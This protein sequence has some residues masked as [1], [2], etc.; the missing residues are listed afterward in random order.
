M[1]LA[2]D[3]HSHS[4][5]SGG[6]GKISLKK[7]KE[8]MDKKGIDV[9]GT[10]DCLHPFWLNKLMSNLIEVKEGIF[11]LSPKDNKY[12]IL[13][14]EIV[15]TAPI[16]KNRRKSVHTVL[17]FPSFST[18][19]KVINLFRNYGVK[20]TIGRPFVTFQSTEEVSDFL[21]TLKA[22]DP[23]ITI[24]PAHIM[25]PDG[26]FGSNNPITYLEDFFGEYTENIKL[27]ETG[28]SADPEML[29]KI[30]QCRE[31]NYISNSD[32]HS[33]AIHRIGREFTLVEVD[34][35]SYPAIVKALEGNGIVSTY[36]FNPREGK[37][38]ASGHR[39]GKY[40]H[41]QHFYTEDSENLIC[42]HCKKPY[43]KGVKHRIEELSKAQK[44]N[45][46]IKKERKF[47]RI[48]PLVE[49]IAHGLNVKTLT[50]KRVISI[51]E[52][53]V[54]IAGSEVA[55]WLKS[56][57]FIEKE[58]SPFLD[59]KLLKTIISVHKGEFTFDPPG[60]DGEYGKLKI[61]V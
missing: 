1:L 51:Y 14:T 46:P 21:F 48:I 55:L 43:T 11:A 60:F 53:I 59:D 3:L 2:L 58:L 47:K 57:D 52:K 37:F 4:G 34:E 49:V 35:I 23:L 20:N 44:L 15:L 12:F 36:E 33:H 32:C 40:N 26:I 22:I 18:A 19:E 42:P 54:E 5:Y 24:F 39:K 25:T 17:L 6:V 28:L 45:I 38:Y 9:F 29:E 16:T 8:S 50:S 30:P 7:I 13:Q 31:R 61:F 41:P 10:G 27:L 56:I